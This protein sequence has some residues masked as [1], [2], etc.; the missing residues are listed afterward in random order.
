MSDIAG[1][2][3]ADYEVVKGIVIASYDDFIRIRKEDGSALGFKVK[4]P[5][6]ALPTGTDVGVVAHRGTDQAIFLVDRA[7]GQ[8]F[9]Q[10]IWHNQISKS[11]GAGSILFR[12]AVLVILLIPLLGQL[13]AFFGGIGAIV[14][15]L[16]VSSSMQG[17]AR[18][19]IWRILLSL[20]IYFLGSF[21]FFSGWFGGD[22]SEAVLG[23]IVL[24]AGALAYTFW[25]HRPVTRYYL[26]VNRLLDEAAA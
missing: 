5:A 20:G 9:N 1:K 14:G 18:A 24:T 16:I 19:P 22:S 7:T 12:I 3:R 17:H 8:R 21:F 26:E 2:A 4:G 23:Y 11:P 13:G 10:S 25:V 15:G 6:A